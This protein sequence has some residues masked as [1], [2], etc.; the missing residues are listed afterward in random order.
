MENIK[1]SDFQKLDEDCDESNCSYNVNKG[2]FISSITQV[3]E[4][5]N[6]EEN[7]IKT[8]MKFSVELNGVVDLGKMS[9]SAIIFR[10]KNYWFNPKNRKKGDGLVGE[11]QIYDP[12]ICENVAKW[13][14]KDGENICCDNHK[15]Y[16]K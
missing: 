14:T 1:Y 16:F 8:Y 6:W 3:S 11:L 10:D 12:E 15:N 4:Y 7:D 9:E 5:F 13:I 2:A